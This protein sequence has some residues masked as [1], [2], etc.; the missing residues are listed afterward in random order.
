MKY[1]ITESQINNLIFLYLDGQGF[2]QTEKDDK[3]HFKKSD[4]DNTSLIV[5][6]TESEVCKL[7]HRVIN[8]VSDF[9]SI[10]KS[11]SKE[12]IGKWVEKT[13]KMNVSSIK[14]LVAAQKRVGGI[15]S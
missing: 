8:Q 1:I 6:D 10:D 13:L 3:I 11:D 7:S 12:L 5:Y 9:F 2:V 15:W 4:G 14:P